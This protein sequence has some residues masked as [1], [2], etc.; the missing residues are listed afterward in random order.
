MISATTSPPYCRF[1]FQPS[2]CPVLSDH[3]LTPACDILVIEPEPDIRAIIQTSLELTTTWQVYLTHSYDEG[4]AL[5][6]ILMPKVILLN[7]PFT[8]SLEHKLLKCFQQLT[9]QHNI[10]L[11]VMLDRV[12]ASDC[13]ALGEMGIYGIIPKPFDCQQVTQLL[14]DWLP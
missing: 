10:V 8:L 7:L 6:P 4:L 13:Q 14:L 11:A 1:P 5:I 2:H 3:A 9:T 12:R